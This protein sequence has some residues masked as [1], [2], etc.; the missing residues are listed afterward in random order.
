MP[1]LIETDAMNDGTEAGLKKGDLA[2]VDSDWEAQIEEGKI[3]A[4]WSDRTI[5]FGYYQGIKDIQGIGQAYE[6]KCGAEEDAE[7]EPVFEDDIIG[8]HKKSIK[9]IGYL[10]SLFQTSNLGSI[11]VEAS[12]GK[13]DIYEADGS[14][15]TQWEELHI[16]EGRSRGGSL[17]ENVIA[18][19]SGGEYEFTIENTMDFT[20]KYQLEMKD[21]N[22]IDIPMHFKL[23]KEDGT[24][25]LGSKDKWLSADSLK[26]GIIPEESLASGSNSKYVLEWEWPED[27]DTGGRTDSQIGIAA[28]N[29]YP[30]YYKLFM[31]ITL[32]GELEETPPQNKEPETGQVIELKSPKTGDVNQIGKILPV[33]LLSGILIVMTACYKIKETLKRGLRRKNNEG[34]N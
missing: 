10:L 3:V 13:T 2:L 16:F 11:T 19:A 6:M 20:V 34:E 7:I 24:Y 9:K 14:S 15:W 27:S 26:K 29:E 31:Q 32:Q 22:D 25:L 23:R 5:L 12:E 21:E 33:I 1:I 28:L 4:F 30:A 17:D 8:I 18:P